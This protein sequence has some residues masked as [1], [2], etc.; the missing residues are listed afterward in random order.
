MEPERVALRGLRVLDLTED[1]GQH[2]TKLLA[3]LGAD[4]IKVEIP[5]GVRARRIGPF[6]DD[7]PHPEGSLY[8]AYYNA[9]KRSITLDYSKTEGAR[10]LKR[11]VERTDVLVEGFAPGY[12]EEVG[13]GYMAL[14]EINPRLIMASITG[15]GQGGPH[16]HFLAPDI[17]PFAMSGLMYI[18]G[19]PEG[20]PV[21]APGSQPYDLASAQAAFG[22]LMALYHRLFSG[23]GQ[24][25]EVSAQEAVACEEHTISR[26]SLDGHIVA[27][28]GSQHGTAAPARIYRSQDGYVHLFAGPHWKSFR[29]WMGSPEVLADPLWED[30]DFRRANIDLVNPLIEEFTLSRG[31]EELVREAQA[32]HLP[33]TPVNTPADFIQSAQTQAR[34]YLLEVEHPLL[35]R[36]L[37]PGA[38]YRLSETP[39]A[40]RRPA[41]LLGEANEEIYCGELG[42][43][44]EEMVAL[45]AWRVI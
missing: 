9:N 30:P 15:F 13:L 27:R 2:C 38:P 43:S 18:S 14:R 3:D 33:C 8:F 41:P 29:E 1:A 16:R 19:K 21:T 42:Y 40:L 20:P 26:F 4:V 24:H 10:I 39:W 7:R 5:G 22:I 28:E 23:K 25:V 31:R 44:R 12:L 36:Y 35:G 17:V 37:Y 32:R 6:K 45:A 34:G 11:L